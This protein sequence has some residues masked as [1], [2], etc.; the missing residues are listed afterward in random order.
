MSDTPTLRIVEV[1]TTRPLAGSDY[2]N[3]P[4]RSLD[5]FAAAQAQAKADRAASDWGHQATHPTYDTNR[6]EVG[7]LRHTA[8]EPHAD[9]PRITWYRD[10]GTVTF[11]GEVLG[12]AF[13]GSA[14]RCYGVHVEYRGASL[15]RGDI[16]EIG[17]LWS[18]LRLWMSEQLLSEAAS[19]VAAQ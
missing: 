3:R 17:Q 1:D 12:M 18:R 14:T 19:A 8:T 15:I 16:E 5:E 10:T 11:R 13:M 4:I 7:S 6:G 9:E 2:L